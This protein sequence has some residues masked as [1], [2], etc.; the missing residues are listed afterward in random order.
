VTEE[1][2]NYEGWTILE[3]MGHRRLGGYVREQ[4]IAGAAF[5]RIDVPAT[6]DDPAATQFYSAQAVYAITP[7]TEAM[8]R[9]VAARQR[10]APVQRWELPAIA[11]TSAGARPSAEDHDE[12][13]DDEDDFDDE[14]FEDEDERLEEE[15]DDEGEQLR[16][17]EL[18][19]V[20]NR[21]LIRDEIGAMEGVVAAQDVVTVAN[22]VHVGNSYLAVVLHSTE[23]GSYVRIGD[24]EAILHRSEIAT[25]WVDSP[26]D[27]LRDDQQVLVKV[28]EITPAGV[29]HVS[30]RALLEEAT[31]AGV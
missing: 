15:R 24:V 17:A 11:G 3:L 4:E 9:A 30:R 18:V 5:L 20:Q 12:D 2:A 27:H 31:A 6:D 14:E 8:A 1:K 16:R 10:P 26:T 22:L 7:T 23:R 25:E 19:R 13:L 28:T 29:V 21:D